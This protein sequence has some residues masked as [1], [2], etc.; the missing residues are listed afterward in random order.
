MNEREQNGSV[1]DEDESSENVQERLRGDD[2]AYEP[3][4]EEALIDADA[5][6]TGLRGPNREHGQKDK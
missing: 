1:P 3:I 5:I 6:G 2:T 4:S